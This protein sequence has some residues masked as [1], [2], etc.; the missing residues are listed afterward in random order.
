M[1]EYFIVYICHIIHSSTDQ[2]LGYFHVLATINNAAVNIG[3]QTSFWYSDLIS[4]GYIPKREIAK[5]G[6]SSSFNFLRNL[7]NLTVSHSGCTYLYSYLNAFKDK[8]RDQPN[9]LIWASFFLWTPF[10]FLLRLQTQS[11]SQ[12]EGTSNP[13]LTTPIS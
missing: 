6:G 2:H 8:S 9:K 3:V 12:A 4:F 7:K 5:P 1:T 11:A 10:R 13:Q